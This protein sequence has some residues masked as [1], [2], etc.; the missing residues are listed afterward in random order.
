MKSVSFRLLTGAVI[1]AAL[2]G[3]LTGCQTK[4]DLPSAVNGAQVAEVH[5]AVRMTDAAKQWRPL[6]PGHAVGPGS[7]IQTAMESAADIVVAGGGAA[8]VRVLM[9]SDTVIAIQSLPNATANELQLDLRLGWLTI[10]STPGPESPLC[11]IKF[12]KGLA[13]G[14]GATFNV[15]A[16]GRVKVMAGT[17]VVKMLDDQPAHTVSAGMQFN[18]Q[19][20][21]ISPAPAGTAM[22]RP[23]PPPPAAPRAPAPAPKRPAT[24]PF[25]WIE[26]PK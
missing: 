2:A 7:L 10:T 5:G 12:P 4:G 1:S 14:R 8:S 9:Q 18:P 25:P 15:T 11:E 3:A 26:R 24:S 22:E 17:V 16:E 21:E 23:G 6:R 20:G 13:G 19:T